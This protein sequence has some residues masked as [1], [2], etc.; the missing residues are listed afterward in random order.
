MQSR[1]FDLKTYLDALVTEY[2]TPAFIPADPISFPN[3]FRE[4]PLSC[5]F[6]GFIAAL[7]SYGR[8]DLIL[9]LL[10]RIFAPMMPDPHDFL[11]A[12]HPKRDAKLYQGLIYRFNRG[13]DLIFLL[14]RLQWAYREY[15]SLENLWRSQA[16]PET[17]VKDGLKRFMSGLVGNHAPERY[18]LKFL[19]SD[20]D[21]G[22][23]CKRLNMFL[24]WMTRQDGAQASI[25][26]GI[27]RSALPPGQLIIPLDTH[28]A[29]SARQLGLTQRKAND[30]KTA[31]EITTVLRQ[32][33]PE[34]PVKYD[35]ALFGHSVNLKNKQFKDNATVLQKAL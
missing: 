29:Q 11:L 35:F 33:C 26:F 31:E 32:F 30:W 15:G 28:V 1:S 14:Q 5:E 25:D 6:V 2:K 4:S 22:G 10:E 3:R 13:D 19:F 21:K 18:G 8:R 16:T 9:A 20:P 24:R 27:W 17:A 12:F 7:F 23:G 34:D